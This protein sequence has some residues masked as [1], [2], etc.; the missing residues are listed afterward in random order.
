MNQLLKFRLKAFVLTALLLVGA[1]GAFAQKE[2]VAIVNAGSSGSRLYLYAVDKTAHTVDFISNDK[3]DMKL[4]EID[5]CNVGGFFDQIKSKYPSKDSIDLYILATAGMRNEDKSKVRRIYKLLSPDKDPYE[6]RYSLKKVMTISG[7]YEGLYAWIAANYDQDKLPGRNDR[8]PEDS[9]GILEIGGASMQIA[10]I[11]KDAKKLNPVD[12]IEHPEYGTVY[13]KSYIE[14]GVNKMYGKTGG[15]GTRFNR[16]IPDLSRAKDYFQTPV[17]FCGLGGTINGIADPGSDFVKSVN[18]KADTPVE[19]DTKHYQFNAIYLRWVLNQLN[20][21]D[22]DK[23]KPRNADW[24]K[25]AAYDIFI[26]GQT[27]EEFNYELPN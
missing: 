12:I 9:Q 7:R 14:G 6:G 20:L 17:V 8:D 16:C 22:N 11:P 1:S 23:I 13:S 15:D 2:T 3:L 10:F 25:G 27:P 24:T 18:E 5:S 19:P 4:S 26:N 21:L